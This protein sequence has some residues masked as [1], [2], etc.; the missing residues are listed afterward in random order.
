MENVARIVPVLY[1][2]LMTRMPSTPIASCANRR[3]ARLDPGG[4]KAARATNDRLDQREACAEVTIA[5]RPMPTR[6]VAN[7]VQTVDRTV[8][9]LVHSKP[10]RSSNR[11]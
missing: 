3:P 7:S 11:L 4:S 5:P 6:A 8:V 9:N 1:S 10:R 2:A